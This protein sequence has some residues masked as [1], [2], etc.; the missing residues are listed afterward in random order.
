L[1]ASWQGIFSHQ[2]ANDDFTQV[3]AISSAELNKEVSMQDSRGRLFVSVDLELELG[4]QSLDRQRALERVATHLLE[5]LGRHEIPATVAVADPVLSAATEAIVAGPLEHEVAVLADATWAGRGAGRERLAREL[6]RRFSRGQELGLNLSTLALRHVELD[7]NLD[8]LAKSGI[9]AVRSQAVAHAGKDSPAPSLL[10]FGVWQMPASAR[11]PVARRWWFDRAAGEAGRALVRAA[12]RKQALG[13]VIDGAQLIDND[14]GMSQVERLLR[15]A[16]ELRRR[17]ELV[18]ETMQRY[19]ASLSRPREVLP[20]R[21]I[22]RA[23]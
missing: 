1:P 14:A 10:R 18:V 11:L 8:L 20:L 22:L 2:G 7:E 23:A 17:E 3:R 16:G 13:M 19:V 5:L 9:T 6:S 12:R 4:Q 15:L 21:S